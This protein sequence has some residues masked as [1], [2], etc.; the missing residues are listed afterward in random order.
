MDPVHPSAEPPL[1]STD[2]R[3]GIVDRRP[4]PRGG[5]PRQVQAW[6][7]VGI[8]FLILAVILI[9]GRPEPGAA[10]A[11][12]SAPST[13]IAPERV[14]DYQARLTEQEARLREQLATALRRA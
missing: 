6:I 9:T 3:G 1:D 13:T 8:A 7:M 12:A 2:V 5:L 4:L 14:R 10:G 11:T